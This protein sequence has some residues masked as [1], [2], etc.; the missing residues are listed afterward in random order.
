MSVS[1]VAY[2]ALKIEDFF[3]SRS[4]VA[5]PYS[6]DTDPDLAL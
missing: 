1:R 5:D 6:F 4:S 2:L 3:Y